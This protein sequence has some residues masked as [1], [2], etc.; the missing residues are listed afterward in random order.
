MTELMIYGMGFTTVTL[1]FLTIFSLVQRRSTGM[2][3]LDALSSSDTITV[4]PSIIRQEEDER[5]FKIL[6]PFRERLDSED[7][8]KKSKRANLMIMAGYYNSNAFTVLYITRIVLAVVMAAI[9]SVSFTFAAR[10]FPPLTIIGTVTG[11]TLFGYFLPLL[12]VKSK[13]KERQQK[14]R[15]GLPDAMDMLLVSLEA[16]LSFPA[17]LKHV[18]TE[19]RDVHPVL[20]EQFEMVTLEF[21]AGRQRAQ[22]LRNLA[23]RVD[24]QEIHSMTTMI[25]QSEELGTSLTSALRA[26]A[27]DRGKGKCTAC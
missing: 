4:G 19:M 1:L 27:E 16:G 20:A 26:S 13:I 24:L 6:K 25:I 8:E 14:V 17:S 5:F 18:A 15:D 2:E 7:M 11:L 12:F 9:A 3:R 10:S 21:R 22:A 23:D